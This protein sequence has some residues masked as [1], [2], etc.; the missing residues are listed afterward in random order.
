[1]GEPYFFLCSLR[2]EMELRV[3]EGRKSEVSRFWFGR[4]TSDVRDAVATRA[5]VLVLEEEVEVIAHVQ[6]VLGDVLPL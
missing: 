5:W 3:G 4:M 2:F 6:Q 1:M